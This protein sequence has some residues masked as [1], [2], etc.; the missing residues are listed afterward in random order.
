MHKT[1]NSSLPSHLDRFTHQRH[2]VT[3][4]FTTTD[5]INTEQAFKDNGFL[6]NTNDIQHMTVTT[7]HTEII[8]RKTAAELREARDGQ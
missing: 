7:T 6:V 8:R 2:T 4:K 1:G 5:A 3:V